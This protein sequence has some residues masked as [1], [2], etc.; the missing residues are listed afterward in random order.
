MSLISSEGIAFNA[1][2]VVL[3]NASSIFG[4][5]LLMI[6]FGANLY[7]KEPAELL[8]L[9]LSHIYDDSARGGQPQPITINSVKQLLDFC[10]EY[11]MSS[12][13][14]CLRELPDRLG[15]GQR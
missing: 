13:I 6:P 11:E 2:R 3:T 5:R 9:V 4:M 10:L 1:H 15:F 8:S 14:S 7:M 12:G